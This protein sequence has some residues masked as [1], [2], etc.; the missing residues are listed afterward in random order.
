[1]NFAN[2]IKKLSIEGNPMTLGLSELGMNATT[3]SVLSANVEPIVE[4]LSLKIFQV[5]AAPSSGPESVLGAVETGYKILSVGAALLN[6]DSNNNQFL[7]NCY[8]LYGQPPF[9]W[10]A[11]GKSVH[12]STSA[13]LA[14]YA[15]AVYDPDDLLD[16]RFF[17]SDVSS[18]SD[19]PSASQSVA[20]GYLMTG[21]GVSTDPENDYGLMLR[22]S[23]PSST[24]TWSA[25]A[26]QHSKGCSGTAT[27]YAIGIKWNDP[28]DKPTLTTKIM[29]ATSGASGAPWETLG[30]GPNYTLV[31][32]GARVEDSPNPNYNIMLQDSYPSGFGAQAIW[33]VQG[34]DCE[35]S[36]S[37]SITA[38]AI[39]LQVIT[40]RNKTVPFG[41]GCQSAR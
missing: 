6:Q 21:G 11:S 12:K 41:P 24:T 40:S 20:D 5:N 16:V 7:T 17:G 39:G 2:L 13:T 32:G 37:N 26:A 8:M 1:M 38:Y 9:Q 25:Y 15:I 29:S 33:S 36:A 18:F 14:S 19:A 22:A 23:Y 3:G 30:V 10:I 4:P 27:A 35:T 28:T 31:G 34:H